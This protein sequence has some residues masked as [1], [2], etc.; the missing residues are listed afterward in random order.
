MAD[1]TGP[2][3][4]EEIGEHVT[5]DEF[6]DRDPATLSIDDAYIVV[7]IER[8]KRAQYITAQEQKKEE[9]ANG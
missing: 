2:E 5:L 8:K 6:Y 7:G 9:K 4:V 3:L 1:K